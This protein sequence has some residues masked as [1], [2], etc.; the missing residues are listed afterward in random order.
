ML[1]FNDAPAQQP[2]PQPDAQAAAAEISFVL[3]GAQ[4]TAQNNSI[5]N[6]DTHVMRIVTGILDRADR[7]KKKRSLK[8]LA[9]G[10]G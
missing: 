9:K 4:V 3:E 2:A 8:V 6:V 10:T 5:P 7:A 1:D